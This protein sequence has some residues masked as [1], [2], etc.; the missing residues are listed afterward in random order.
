MPRTAQKLTPKAIRD[1]KPQAKKHDTRDGT[2]PGLMVVTAPSGRKTWMLEYLRNGKRTRISFTS[3]HRVRGL[4]LP[5]VNPVRE[6]ACPRTFAIV[7]STRTAQ[8]ARVGHTR[9]QGNGGRCWD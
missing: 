6:R 7:N 2:V 3:G 8:S 9:W 1:L 5:E 4:R